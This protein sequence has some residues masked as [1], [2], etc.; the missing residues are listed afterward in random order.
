MSLSN[1]VYPSMSLYEVFLFC[2]SSAN[3]SAAMFACLP[4]HACR[5]VQRHASKA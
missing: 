5:L 4:A 1:V 2:M 3:V